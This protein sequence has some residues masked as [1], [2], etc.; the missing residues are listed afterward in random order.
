MDNI[1]LDKNIENLL[2]RE[3]EV[4]ACSAGVSMYPMLRNKKDMIVVETVKRKLRKYDVPLYR[5]ESGKLVLHRIIKVNPDHYVIRGDNLTVKEYIYPDQIIGVLKSFYRGGKF[6]DCEKSKKYKLYVF[7]VCH[8]Y[9]LRYPWKKIIR[10]FLGKTKRFVL[11]KSKI[12]F[13][14][15]RNE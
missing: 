4:M 12:F 6:V 15:L 11:G 10:P 5:L 9:F 2:A 3:G 1:F 7:C 13:G 8:S 14:G